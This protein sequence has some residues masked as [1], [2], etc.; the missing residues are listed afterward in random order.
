MRRRHLIFVLF[1]ACTAVGRGSEQAADFGSGTTA[2]VIDVIVR[3]RQGRP[4]TDLQKSDFEL[5][6]NGARQEISDLTVVMPQPPDA[7]PRHVAPDT[8]NRGTARAASQTAGAISFVALVFDRLSPEGRAAAAK[9]ARAALSSVGESDFVGVFVND[10]SLRTLQTFTNDKSKAEAALR[11]ASTSATAVRTDAEAVGTGATGNR[12]PSTPYTAGA[13]QAGRAATRTPA[14]GDRSTDA[15]VKADEKMAEMARRMDSTYEQLSR[16]HQGFTTTNG[17]LA[18]ISALTPLPGR[19]SIVLFAESLAIPIA[20]QGRFDAVIQNANRANVSI[21]AVDAAGLRVHSDQAGV[22]RELNCLAGTAAGC[23]DVWGATGM[24]YDLADL[25]VDLLRKDP[26]TA[27]GTLSRATGGFLV[28]N[29]NDLASAFRQIDADRRFHYLLSYTPRNQQF[30]GEWRKVVVKVSRPAVVRA[31]SGFL[32][33]RSPSVLPILPHEAAPLA[34]LDRSPRPTDVPI[35][36]GAYYFP[37]GDQ[38]RVTVLAATTGSR[39]EFAVDEHTDTFRTDFTILVRIRDSNGAIVRKASEVYR[40]TGPVSERDTARAGKILFFRQPTLLP[41]Q[42]TL[43]AVVHDSLTGRS[44]VAERSFEVPAVSHFDVSS[45]IVVGRAERIADP[46]RPHDNPLQVGDVLLYPDLEPIISRGADG[47]MLFLT[48][49][50]T[51]HSLS[52]TLQIV[53]GE[54]PL[55]TLPA[56][57]DRAAEGKLQQLWRVP[58][59]GFPAGQYTIRVSVTD[60]AVTETRAA[61]F[62]LVDTR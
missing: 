24:G 49:Q 22:A 59:A 39:V 5:F 8:Q 7:S 17:L 57:F 20:V 34:V 50:T 11:A 38:G 32:A 42:Y 33:V 35:S 13:E 52:G 21:Y 56:P 14:P 3:D 48:V 54:I 28:S 27:L 58:L 16:E 19:K 51:A 29:T 37:M 31:R 12:S 2:V 46:K 18:L 45:L 15:F 30:N 10:L 4:I 25:R 61:S 47:V 23:E 26:A 44:G 6:E 36:A 1:A 62:D 40:L 60:G 55:V 53:K 9:G 41:G 43:E